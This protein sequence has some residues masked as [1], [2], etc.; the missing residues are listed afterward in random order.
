[1]ADMRDPYRDPYSDPQLRDEYRRLPEARSS[2]AAW[3]WIAGAVIVVLILG[4]IFG[5]GRSTQVASNAPNPPAVTS[6]AMPG[7]PASPP[8]PARTPPST[9][10]QGVH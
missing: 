7:G 6:P 4:F 2:G 9:T 5:W 1:M 8:P 3:G 10:G